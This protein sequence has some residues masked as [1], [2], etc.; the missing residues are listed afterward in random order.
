[1]TTIMK[2]RTLIGT[3]GTSIGLG[4]IG[5]VSA[6]HQENFADVE[7]RDQKSDGIA[8]TVER[9]RLEAD[10]FIT[11]HTWD[12]IEK[13]DGP[14]TIAGVSKP[15]E[16][17]EYTEVDV[18]LFHDGTGYSDGF[19]QDQLDNGRH[20]LVAV[21]HRDTD[22]TGDFDF[23]STPHRDVPFTNGTQMRTDLPV[24]GA[25]NDVARIVVSPGVGEPPQFGSN[26][27]LH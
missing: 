7:L 12:L 27:P 21:P 6:D 23:V 2:R 13:Q 15:F 17:G 4:T 19:D 5:M 20:R 1:M 10:G 3:I 16:P 18:P 11:I 9:L 24:D 22:H 26:T 8:V 25:V 14:N